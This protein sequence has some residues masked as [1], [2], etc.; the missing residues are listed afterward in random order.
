MPPDRI[1]MLKS[2]QNMPTRNSYVSP[3]CNPLITTDVFVSFFNVTVCGPSMTLISDDTL[4]CIV[5][6]Q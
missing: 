4:T 3:D 1:S 6:M 2:V 5:Q